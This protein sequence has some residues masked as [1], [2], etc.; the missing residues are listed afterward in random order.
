MDGQR[1]F[2]IVGRTHKSQIESPDSSTKYAINTEQEEKMRLWPIL[3]LAFFVF[4][5]QSEVAESPT[6]TVVVEVITPTSIL[7]PT[8]VEQPTEQLPT[9]TK[10][11][12]TEDI[13]L[14]TPAV[15]KRFDE[16]LAFLPVTWADM[17][18]PVDFGPTIY[19]LDMVQMREDLQIFSITGEDSRQDKLDLILGLDTQGFPLAP[20]QTID[21]VSGGMFMEWG[22]DIADVAQM[23]SLPDFKT[24]LYRG[25]FERPEI[26]EWL[27]EKGYSSTTLND[28]D[29]FN[30][31]G[32]VLEFALTS[33]TLI[34]SIWEEESFI[35]LML[36]IKSIAPGLE[37]HPAVQSILAEMIGGWGVALSPSPDVVTAYA[38]FNNWTFDNELT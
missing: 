35:A 11:P 9:P 4:A 34:M 10:L 8:E 15:S 24:T 25:N 18:L 6:P 33:D 14:S 21:P 32:D 2:A 36:E 37:T 1:P 31:E 20:T 3:F 23:M 19:L 28:F 26:R 12:P 22:W 17:H 29:Y 30:K 13:S 7:I 27:L 16:L 5:C 38:S